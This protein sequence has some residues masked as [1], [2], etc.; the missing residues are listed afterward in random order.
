VIPGLPAIAPQPMT[1]PFFPYRYTACMGYP[2]PSFVSLP[3]KSAVSFWPIELGLK[4]LTSWS[5]SQGRAETGGRGEVGTDNGCG[6]GGRQS[7]SSG[8][9]GHGGARPREKRPR[10][11]RAGPFGFQSPGPDSFFLLPSCLPA[12]S[13]SL[14]TSRSA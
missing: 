6:T 7:S 5:G 12:P 13:R 11:E 14:V 10:H 2:H 4:A 3:L 8:R 9:R 1:T